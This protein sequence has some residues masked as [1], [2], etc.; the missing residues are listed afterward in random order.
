[1]SNHYSYS[2]EHARSLAPT[3]VV[4]ADYWTSRGWE[5][6]VNWES[7]LLCPIMYDW[8]EDPF[9]ELLKAYTHAEMLEICESFNTRVQCEGGPDIM[10]D[11]GDLKTESIEALCG[12]VCAF[13][14]TLVEESKPV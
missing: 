8:C 11:D 13:M 7:R 10:T 9:V 2:Q 14:D 1:M 6:P 3:T 5:A 4:D 12:V